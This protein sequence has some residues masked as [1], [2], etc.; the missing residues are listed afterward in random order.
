MM[1]LSSFLL[2]LLLSLSIPTQGLATAAAS[3]V[4][5]DYSAAATGLFN[6]MRTPAALIGGAIVP[7]GL[8]TAPKI[9]KTDSVR[10]RILKKANMLLAVVSLLNEIVAITYSTVAVNKIAELS[11]PPTAG[12]AEYIAKY[13][14]LPWLGTNVHFL[15][16][17]FGFGCLAISKP[18][19]LY[20]KNV[21]H[22][23]ACW[24][25]SAMLLC[26][27]IVNKGIALGHGT[28]EDTSAKLASNFLG[29]VLSY[30]RL[31]L[32]WGSGKMLPPI[33]IS[34]LLLSTVPLKKAWDDSTSA[35]KED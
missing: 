24:T 11:F 21:G 9:E 23:A 29:L 3:A 15:F 19:F 30:T 26:V 7:L 28:V 31:L 14:K 10:T 32:Q 2:I 1:I 35:D 4:L 22:V 20:G 33:A 34:L 25:A 18:Y 17:L 5:K 6:N 16:G 12:A 13:H 27:A 8:L